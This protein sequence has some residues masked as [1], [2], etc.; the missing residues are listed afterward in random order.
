MSQQT[1]LTNSSAPLILQGVGYIKDTQ[2][3]LTDGSRT[4]ALPQYTV[5]SQIASTGKWT[6]WINANLGG[7]T[8]TQYP[9]GIL[10]APVGGVTAAQ[11]VAGDVTGVSILYAGKGCEIDS[12]LLVFD[13]GSTGVGTLNTLS[14]VPTVPTNL[15]KTAEQLFA[16]RGIICVTTTQVDQY[17]N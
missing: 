13:G 8:G 14:S 17:E 3:I 12:S 15:A 10:I 9:M 1:V 5:M 2:T 6:P 16:E 4:V 11:L 7:T